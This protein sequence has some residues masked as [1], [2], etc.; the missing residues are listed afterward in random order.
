MLQNL[1]VL[2]LTEVLIARSAPLLVSID[3]FKLDGVL[4]VLMPNIRITIKVK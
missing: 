2:E 4:E 3:K 1:F